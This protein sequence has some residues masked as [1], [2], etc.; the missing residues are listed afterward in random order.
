MNSVFS[1]TQQPNFC[2]FPLDYESSIHLLTISG[3][4]H[5]LR[6]EFNQSSHVAQHSSSSP[7]NSSGEPIVA[8]KCEGPSTSCFSFGY[9]ALG[10]NNIVERYEFAWFIFVQPLSDLFIIPA[11]VG[12]E[13]EKTLCISLTFRKHGL[14]RHANNTLLTKSEESFLWHINKLWLLLCCVPKFLLLAL[15]GCSLGQ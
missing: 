14:Q 3:D 1:H 9:L 10:N 4:M 15:L 8:E 11:A 13:E 5:I 2:S 6:Y 12:R 7:L